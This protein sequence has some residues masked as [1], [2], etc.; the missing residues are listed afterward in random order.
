MYVHRRNSIEVPEGTIVTGT[1][2]SI[3]KLTDLVLL[4]EDIDFRPFTKVT[5]VYL[6]PGSVECTDLPKIIGGK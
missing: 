2:D 4:C 3:P 6:F 1:V 5:R